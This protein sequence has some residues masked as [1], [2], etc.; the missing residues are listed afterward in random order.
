MIRR[1]QEGRGG[2]IIGE[3]HFKAKGVDRDK[4][5]GQTPLMTP[6]WMYAV[7][8]AEV[9]VDGGTGEI[10]LVRLSGG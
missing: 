5:T 4:E 7:Q 8:G 10:R 1:C 9:E 3:G 6:F 2:V